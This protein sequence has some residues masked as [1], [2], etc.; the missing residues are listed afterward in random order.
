[1]VK[2]FG[3]TNIKGKWVGIKIKVEEDQVDALDD[4][5]L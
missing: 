3:N 5:D 1:M 2:K 4:L